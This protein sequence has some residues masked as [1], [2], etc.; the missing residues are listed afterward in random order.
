ME[1]KLNYIRK[2]VMKDEIEMR[3]LANHE[4]PNVPN[5]REFI[6]LEAQ[7]EKTEN[8][9]LELSENFTQLL[10]NHMELT[11]LCCVLERTQVKQKLLT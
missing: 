4:I 5:P 1:R 11:E 3:D 8:E 6:N 7:F 2:E 10:K 9:V